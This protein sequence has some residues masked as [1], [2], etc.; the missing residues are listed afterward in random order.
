MSKKSTKGAAWRFLTA[1]GKMLEEKNDWKGK[2]LIIR[3][4]EVENFQLIHVER[5]KNVCLGKDAGMAHWLSV[6]SQPS[7]QKPEPAR[8]L[9]PK[10]ILKNLG[11]PSLPQPERARAC[12][13]EWFQSCLTSPACLFTFRYH[14]QQLFHIL[15]YGDQV[16]CWPD[17]S[18]SGRHRWKHQRGTFPADGHS[19]KSWWGASA[20]RVGQCLGEQWDEAVL[21]LQLWRAT[22]PERTPTHETCRMSCAQQSRGWAIPC[23]GRKNP[24]PI[25]GLDVL[26]LLKTLSFSPCLPFG[27]DFLTLCPTH[28]C[29]L[30]A[31]N[32]FDFPVHSWRALCLRG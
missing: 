32:L 11:S 19:C 28:S 6:I 9:I 10:G 23:Y 16:P 15:F 31:Q 27:V 1:Y 18:P 21:G 30:E 17:G 26:D 12:W 2:L 24:F 8:S 14:T 5:N 7:K 29:I 13:A 20:E 3:E 25:V 4:T 22:D